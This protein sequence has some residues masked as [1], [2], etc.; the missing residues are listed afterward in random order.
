MID[1]PLKEFPIYL[2]LNFLPVPWDLQL[3]ICAADEA[4]SINAI[5]GLELS[6]APRL[7]GCVF[8]TD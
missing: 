3:C 2:S 8:V 5:L 1:F 4:Q 7:L 6:M